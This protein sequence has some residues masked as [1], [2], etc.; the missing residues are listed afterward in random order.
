VSREP[1]T[2]YERP[3]EVP[4]PTLEVVDE[5][6]QV[7]QR[8]RLNGR[9][10]VG[11]SH[12]NDVVLPE[13]TVSRTHAS[14]D[15]DGHAVLVEDL[16]SENGTWLGGD[17]LASDQ[18][19]PWTSTLPLRIGSYTL[20]LR[21][22]QRPNPVGVSHGGSGVQLALEQAPTLVPG[23]VAQTQLTL[24]NTGQ[25]VDHLRLSVEGVPSEW[26]HVA[27]QEVP[28][29]PGERA[30]IKLDI[31]VPRA[32]DALAGPHT[33]T[34]RAESSNDPACSDAR[35]ADWMV[36]PFWDAHLELTPVRGQG[37]TKAHYT[38]GLVNDG[39]TVVRYRLA[40]SGDDDKVKLQLT[41][42]ALEVAAGARGVA[43]LT[44][45]APGRLFG[46]PELHGFTI[47]ATLTGAAAQRLRMAGQ[48]AHQAIGC[49]C[50]GLLALLAGGSILA[51]AGG[52][53]VQHVA[54]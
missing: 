16:G 43:H 34:V 51:A 31:Q 46:R 14:I 29:N 19:R 35:Q 18:Q 27:P 26:V 48:F 33:V 42:D 7:R 30:I 3:V 11:R 1:P 4:G 39:N 41:P 22:D 23:Q 38:I 12:T 54:P 36:A 15:W 2:V 9:V 37:H 13:A 52:Y 20:R 10:L 47:E 6:G 25:R 50:L 21:D 8:I 32:A 17:R 28:L 40:A 24:V 44:L 45:N 49:G 53:V 5:T